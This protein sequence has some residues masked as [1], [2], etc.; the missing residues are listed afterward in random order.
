MVPLAQCR[1][2]EPPS[3]V[4]S[5][6]SCATSHIQRTGCTCT[7]WKTFGG[8]CARCTTQRLVLTKAS[9]CM[10]NCCPPL[11][12]YHHH[13]GMKKQVMHARGKRRGETPNDTRQ[14]VSSRISAH[15]S[16]G[17]PKLGFEKVV[18]CCSRSVTALWVKVTSWDA[19][20]LYC[21]SE[22][23]SDES[24]RKFFFLVVSRSSRGVYSRIVMA[25]P[26]RSPVSALFAGA[27]VATK[28]RA[29]C[30][31]EHLT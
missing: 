19:T 29:S 7:S 4:S 20:L 21:V 15:T 2:I 8:A 24:L 9:I 23:R 25:M 16:R 10:R 22:H 26:G 17:K 12:K 13:R 30:N 28:T 6:P 5:G 27:P 3:R 14:I 18:Q 1:S 11:R 31:V